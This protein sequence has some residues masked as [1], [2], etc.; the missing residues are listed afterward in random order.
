MKVKIKKLHPNAVIPAYSKQGD[1]ALDLTAVTMKYDDFRNIVYGTGLSM[2]IP[3]GYVGLLYPRSSISKTGLALCNSVGVIDSGYRGEIM[4][5]Y[6]FF[7]NLKIWNGNSPKIGD[8]VGQ[9]MIIPH[10]K[11]EFIE[12][13]ELSNS[14]RGTGGFGSTGE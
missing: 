7:R 6:R 5:K 2:E 14:D 9:I 11:V 12:V 13:N 8:R 1:A 4:L 10:P 3:E